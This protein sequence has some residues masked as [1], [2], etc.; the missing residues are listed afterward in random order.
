MGWTVYY[1]QAVAADSNTYR[2]IQRSITMLLKGCKL[3]WGLLTMGL[4]SSKRRAG[5]QDTLISF[6]HW[7]LSSSGSGWQQMYLEGWL[8]IKECVGVLGIFQRWVQTPRNAFL[9]SDCKFFIKRWSLFPSSW[10]CT[11][12]W[13]ALINRT[14]LNWWCLMFGPVSWEPSSFPYFCSRGRQHQVSPDSPAQGAR[15]RRALEDERAH[16]E[17]PSSRPLAAPSA[18]HICEAIIDLPAQLDLQLQV[19]PDKTSRGNAQPTHR[20]TRDNKWLWFKVT[21]FWVL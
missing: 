3:W 6:F 5:M 17:K 19:S 9:Y 16:E 2:L 13:L 1:G 18:N 14:Q 10:T 7:V 12:L 15:W 21:K 11:G 8:H 20:I 4:K